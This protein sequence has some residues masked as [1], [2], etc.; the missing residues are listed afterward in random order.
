MIDTSH[1]LF[2]SFDG[3]AKLTL[4]GLSISQMKE[5]VEILQEEIKENEE[6]P[7]IQILD[8]P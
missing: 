4:K 5:L 6:G 1:K 3:A 2:S 7:P 8:I